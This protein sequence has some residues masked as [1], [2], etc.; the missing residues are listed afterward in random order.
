MNTHYFQKIFILLNIQNYVG[1]VHSITVDLKQ[2]QNSF[3][4]SKRKSTFYKTTET[5]AAANTR[6]GQ[7]IKMSNIC[8]FQNKIVNKIFLQT[9]LIIHFWNISIRF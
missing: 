4:R 9:I 5:S 8:V 2:T 7:H 3:F 6:S 1:H